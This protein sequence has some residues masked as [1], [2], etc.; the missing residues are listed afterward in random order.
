VGDSVGFVVV[1][2]GNLVWQGQLRT[3]FKACHGYIY[4]GSLNSVHRTCFKT[5]V[6]IELFIF[7]LV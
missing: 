4:V 5:I 6:W 2:Y 3:W 1:D 7:L